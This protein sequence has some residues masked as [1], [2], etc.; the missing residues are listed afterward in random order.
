MTDEDVQLTPELASE[1]VMEASDPRSTYFDQM[2]HQ[3]L[4]GEHVFAR[5]VE[6]LTMAV[7]SQLR[8]CNNWFRIMCEWLYDDPPLTELGELEA[9]FYSRAAA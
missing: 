2:R 8:A 7:L 6:L 3:T 1:I 5:R 4:P 9:A